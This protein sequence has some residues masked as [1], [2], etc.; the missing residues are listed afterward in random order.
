MLLTTRQSACA[1]I[2][3][4]VCQTLQWRNW[5]NN[6][7]ITCR[8][9]QTRAYAAAVYNLPSG[10]ACSTAFCNFK[11]ETVLSTERYVAG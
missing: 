9:L 1:L 4:L 3:G 5:Y 10:A 8:V 6:E 11:V 7:K 2:K